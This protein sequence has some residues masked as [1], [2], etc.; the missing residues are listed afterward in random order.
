MTRNPIEIS[1]ERLNDIT[2]RCADALVARGIGSLHFNEGMNSLR[3]GL[4]DAMRTAGFVQDIALRH[5]P[6]WHLTSDRRVVRERLVAA[7][8][9][10]ID[11]MA[12]DI[13]RILCSENLWSDTPSMF[14]KL[15]LRSNLLATLEWCGVEVP[16]DEEL[17]VEALRYLARMPKPL[18][19]A[20][21]RSTDGGFPDE[22]CGI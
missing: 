14:E 3:S 21:V 6:H 20:L 2:M 4:F 13:A 16:A 15:C 12:L 8:S 11:E 7:T 1:Q 10:E 5:N 17:L 22:L 19:A 9:D 18:W